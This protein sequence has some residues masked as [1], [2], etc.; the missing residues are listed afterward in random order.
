MDNLSL[1]AARAKEARMSYGVYM[2]SI[3]S[4]VAVLL[5]AS[6]G[7]RECKCCHKAFYPKDKRHRYCSK[8]C[9]IL[10]NGK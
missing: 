5:E 8:M 2:A 3:Y 4:P 10:A 6:D 1:C 7:I 9:A